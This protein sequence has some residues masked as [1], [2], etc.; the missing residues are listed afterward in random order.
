MLL[1]EIFNARLGKIG[2]GY[3]LG[4]AI[5]KLAVS[6]GSAFLCLFFLFLVIFPFF[7]FFLFS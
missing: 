5:L 2:D 7:Y 3:G 6:W 4:P 1:I